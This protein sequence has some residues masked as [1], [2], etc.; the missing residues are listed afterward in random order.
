MAV[1]APV[2]QGR[3]QGNAHATFRY[4]ATDSR[5][6]SFPGDTLFFA[7]ATPRRN[8]HAF[9][10]DAYGQGVRSFV[11]SEPLD[12]I[13]DEATIITVADTLNALQQLAGW[14][15]MQFKLPVVG[16]TGSNGKTIVK[17]WL[18]EMLQDDENI[19]RSPKSFNSQIG[20]PLSVW[21]LHGQATMGVFE[22]GISQQGEMQKLA[23]IIQPTIGI[24]TMLGDAHNEGFASPKQKLKEKFLLFQ[25]CSHLICHTDDPDVFGQANAIKGKLLDWGKHDNA[26]VRILKL[27]SADSF[28][29]VRL[30]AGEKRFELQVPFTDEASIQNAMHASVYL[31]HRGYDANAINEKLQR[32]RH[33]DMRLQWKKGIHGCYLLN[34]S[35]SNDFA[36][37]LQAFDYLAQQS[38]NSKRTIILSDLSAP[39]ESEATLYT[40]LG[41]LLQS[42][43]IRRFIGVGAAMLRNKHVL[44]QPGMELLLYAST[45]ELLKHFPSIVF[46][47][48]DILLKGGRSFELEQIAAL[49]EAQQ[50]QTLLE[51]NL[52]AMATNLHHYRS[53]ISQGTKMMVMVKAFGYGSGDAEIGRALQFSGIDYLAV[54]FVDEGVALRQ[55][56]VHLPIMVLNT[57]PASFEYMEQYNLEPEVY[58]FEFLQTLLQW[59]RH[60]GI[61]NN[62]VHLKIDTGMHRLGFETQSMDEL[63]LEL[64]K[65]NELV[66]KSVF[67]HLVASEDPGEDSFTAQQL[68]WFDAACTTLRQKLGYSFLQHAANTAAISRHPVAHFDMVRLGVGLYGGSAGLLPVMQLVTTVSQVKKVSAGE[69][70]GYGRQARLHRDSIIA[71][72][73]IGYADGYSRRLGDGVGAM[74]I[75]GKRAQVVGRVCMDMTMLDVTDIPGVQAGDRVQVFGT[76]ISIQEVAQWCGT[77]PYEI[78]TGISQRVKRVYIEET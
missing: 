12:V 19:V 48:E 6:I 47:H 54:A 30:E 28:T 22:A 21:Q 42:R 5:K 72:V 14:H 70:V 37:L 49:L 25:N 53:L 26:W 73:R 45:D 46:Q 16:I 43:K 69:T 11:I 63:G 13:F 58:S 15:R 40:Q 2:M 71:T 41:Q 61:S 3:L 67:T 62:P 77:I 66:V 32:L 57:D 36:S 52:T 64:A 35:Y 38:R 33:L 65:Q 75:R 24:F 18:Y 76:H 17:E 59:C 39:A 34:D 27:E 44:Q 4:L 74:H 23:D 55:S 50:H 56:G 78:M 51:I 68:Q 1:V 29:K 8:G 10:A 31:L 20:V 9:V 60:K 7:L